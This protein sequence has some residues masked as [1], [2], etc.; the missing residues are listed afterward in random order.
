MNFDR[1]SLNKI[2]SMDEESFKNLTRTIAEAAGASKSKASAMLN[3]PE[4]IKRK[5]SQ[6]TPEEASQL[7]DSAGK[8]KSEEIMNM[9]RAQGFDVGK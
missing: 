6:M 8:E 4:F 3:N 5:L 7:V 2:L 9:L 1:E